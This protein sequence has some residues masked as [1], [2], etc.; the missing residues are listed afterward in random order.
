MRNT[1][2]LHVLS[3]AVV[4]VAHVTILALVAARLGLW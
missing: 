2:L 3:A 4:A 1:D